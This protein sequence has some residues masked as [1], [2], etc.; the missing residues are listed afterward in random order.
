MGRYIWRGVPRRD[1]RGAKMARCVTAAVFNK[2]LGRH[3]DNT[4]AA[5]RR[6]IK[7]SSVKGIREIG[8]RGCYWTSNLWGLRRPRP[9]VKLPR[10]SLGLLWPRLTPIRPPAATVKQ[11]PPAAPTAPT[12]SGQVVWKKLKWSLSWSLLERTHRKELLKK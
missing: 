7:S 6:L 2:R 8:A 11:T 1:A 4:S 10:W 3:S 5:A 9:S 12:P